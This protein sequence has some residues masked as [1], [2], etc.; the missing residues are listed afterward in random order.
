MKFFAG[1]KQTR[2][3][4]FLIPPMNLI[5]LS[6]LIIP[7]IFTSRCFRLVNHGDGRQYRVWRQ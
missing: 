3:D 7:P 5:Y 2:L 4:F 6:T 1:K